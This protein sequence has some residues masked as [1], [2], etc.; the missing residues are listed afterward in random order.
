MTD[1]EKLVTHF[2][3]KGKQIRIAGES[4][5]AHGYDGA[6]FII[7][8]T[9]TLKCIDKDFR[10]VKWLRSLQNVSF[11]LKSRLKKIMKKKIRYINWR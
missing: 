6:H 2:G 9:L 11:R 5:K 1:L 10:R 4:I 3:L 8:M 7:D